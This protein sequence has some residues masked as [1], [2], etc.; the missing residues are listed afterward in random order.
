[1]TG[2]ALSNY[3]NFAFPLGSNALAL[4]AVIY[5][6]PRL[7]CIFTVKQTKAVV[8]VTPAP[9]RMLRQPNTN[10]RIG[11]LMPRRKAKGKEKAVEI[12]EGDEYSPPWASD[13]VL[14]Q[15]LQDEEVAV[16]AEPINPPAA[17][18]SANDFPPEYWQEEVDTIIPPPPAAANST[19]SVTEPPSTTIWSP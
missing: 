3:I 14:R 11:Q 10:T 9:T 17:I 18:T 6:Q 8:P 13:E 1:M 15:V 5:L 16:A 2:W 19:T 4:Q 12:V 7:D